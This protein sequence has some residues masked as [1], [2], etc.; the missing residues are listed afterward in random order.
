[1]DA[2]SCETRSRGL[3][4]LP[5]NVVTLWAGREALKRALLTAIGLFAARSSLAEV[6]QG[7]TVQGAAPETNKDTGVAL[8]L[9]LTATTATVP[10]AGFEYAVSR[11]PDGTVPDVETRL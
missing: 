5:T 3:Y 8:V 2:V 11:T 6:T 9:L 10:S 7:V 1:M 4:G